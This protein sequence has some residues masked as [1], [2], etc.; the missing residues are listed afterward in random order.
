M[1]SGP[2]KPPGTPKVTKKVEAVLRE[3]PRLRRYAVALLADRGRADDL[4]QDTLERALS[5][6]HLWQSGTDM[7]RWLFTIMHNLHVNQVRR[8]IRR[9]NET[10]IDDVED[11]LVQS[12]S[13]TDSVIV[14]D[15]HKAMQELPTEQ[16]EVLVL[17]ALEGMAYR[18][19][20][21]VLDIPL[22][23]VMSRL[24]RARQS[25]RKYLDGEEA[26]A[27]RRVK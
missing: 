24:S 1:A 2:G 11:R 15:L 19:V 10:N 23:T 25:L 9:G 3:V 7:R 4:V 14:R 16:V 12:A 5:R 17:I 27:L 13:Q 26:P 21:E 18:E 8:S 20:A 22:G 6:L